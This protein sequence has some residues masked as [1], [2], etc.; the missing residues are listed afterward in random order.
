MEKWPPV[1]HSPAALTTTTTTTTTR[2][3]VSLLPCKDKEE[4]KVGWA[5]YG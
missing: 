3:S 5:S 2:P 4:E 1:E